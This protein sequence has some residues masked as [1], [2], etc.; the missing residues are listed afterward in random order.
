MVDATV[1]VVAT[2]A[3]AQPP[4]G[5]RVMSREKQI[6]GRSLR[7]RFKGILNPLDLDFRLGNDGND[8]KSTGS[9]KTMLLQIK[10]CSSCQA[11]LLGAADGCRRGSVTVV[12]SVANL[13]KNE[14]LIMHHD[15]VDLAHAA[16]EIACDQ[17]E[18]VRFQIIK[19][20]LLSPSAC[21]PAT[22]SGVRRMW[23][24]ARGRCIESELLIIRG[25]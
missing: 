24:V 2:I 1:A 15:E 12:F 20:I 11:A 21:L 8:I 25:E 19:G 22:H 13:N 6:I 4:N 9:V 7:E 18:P 16:Q 3:A 17:F 23:G 5:G 14:M 10:I